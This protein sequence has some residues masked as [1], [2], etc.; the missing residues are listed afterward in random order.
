[1]Q[2]L[3]EINYDFS[4]DNLPKAQHNSYKIVPVKTLLQ[5]AEVHANVK[6][7]FKEKNVEKNCTNYRDY[8]AGWLI[9]RRVFT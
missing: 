9:P 3:F 7:Y 2:K 4:I 5:D 8:R 1:M 6:L